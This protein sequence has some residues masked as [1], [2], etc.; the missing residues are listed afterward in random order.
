MQT[1]KLDVH[2]L[3]VEVGALLIVQRKIKD[4][5]HLIHARH[6]ILYVQLMLQEQLVQILPQHV[7]QQI[8]LLIVHGVLKEF[9]MQVAQLVLKKQH[10]QQLEIVSSPH[11]LQHGLH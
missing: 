6:I 1:Q 3:L 11:R 10:I 8:K 5:S 9:V 7:Q 2:L 4:H